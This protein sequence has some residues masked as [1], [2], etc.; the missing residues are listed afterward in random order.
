MIGSLVNFHQHKI[1]GKPL[2]T[3]FMC[4]KRDKEESLDIQKVLNRNS[5]FNDFTGAGIIPCQQNFQ[6]VFSFPQT[7]VTDCSVSLPVR[8]F[9]SSGL[10]APPVLS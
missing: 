4:T 9:S 5:S 10:R 1:W 3:Q 7:Y 8:Y 2:L 6:L